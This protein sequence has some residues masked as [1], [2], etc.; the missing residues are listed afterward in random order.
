MAREQQS[1][2]PLVPVG[3]SAKER[4]PG[5]GEFELGPAFFEPLPPDE[6]SCW[7]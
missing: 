4:M 2:V 7:E 6:L 1:P 5:M 3:K